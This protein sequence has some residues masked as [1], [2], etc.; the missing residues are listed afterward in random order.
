MKIAI[1]CYPSYGGSGVIATELGKQMAF[2]GHEV[3]FISYERP[4][5]LDLFHE[6]I[7][8]HEVEIL[9]YPLFKFPPY[10]IA[11][12]SKIV[13]IAH[14][15]GLDLVH[16]HYA[17]PH[18]V[19]A[20][21]AREMLKEKQ[22]PFITTLHGT[23]ITLVGAEK[24]FYDVTRFSIEQSDGVTAVSNSLRQETE[25][26]FQITRPIRTIYNFVDTEYFVRK[27]NRTLRRRYA[28]DNERILIHISN[29]RAVKRIEDLCRIYDAVNSVVPS[30]LL[31]VG[32]GPDIATA[33]KYADDHKLQDRILFLG[34]QERVVELLSIADLFLLP[35]EKESFGLVALE[36]MSCEVPVIASRTGGIPEVVDHGKSGFL[37]EI[38]DVHSMAD[39]AIRLLQDNNLREVMAKQARAKAVSSFSQEKII[40][41]YEQ[42]Y[43]D[44]LA[45]NQ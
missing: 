34:K 42:Y 27:M 45:K 1:V 22:V 8:F 26:V 9:E 35:S 16:A 29:F 2:R 4:F 17:I 5:K 20:F 43:R 32:D 6:N 24:Q 37:S 25:D 18:A 7:Y 33:K 15:A 13:E 41:E 40:T 44:I 30:K 38:G 39:H 31:L 14:C 36:A 19:S 21:L 28:H 10:C 3:H 11:L 12:A 23:D